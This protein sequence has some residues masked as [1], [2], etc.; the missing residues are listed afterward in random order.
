VAAYLGRLAAAYRQY[1][2][3]AGNG[4]V[5]A[6]LRLGGGDLRGLDPLPPARSLPVLNTRELAGL[7]HLP[8]AGADVPLLERTAARQRLPLPCT[9]GRGCRIG[10]SA[11]QGHEVPVSLPDELLRRHLLLVA[12]TR[13]GKSSLLLRLARYL[14]E[15]EPSGGRRPAL[16]LVD[17]HRDL[18]ETALGCVPPG[19]HGDVVYL[20]VAE[21]ERPFGLNLLDVGFG[22]ERD[23]AVSNVLD[24]FRHEWGRN[25]GPRMEDAFRY[26]LMTLF[27]ANEELCDHGERACN[28]QFTILDVPAVLAETGFRRWLLEMVADPVIEE[29]WARFDYLD[30]RLQMEIQNPVQT[31]VHKFAGSRAARAIVGQPRSTIDPAAWL[32]D[33]A[34]VLVNTAKGVVGEDTAALIGGTLLN[35]VALVV[36]EQ[37]GLRAS[38]RRPVTLVVDEF[39]S[40][41]GADY[42]SILAELPKYGANL[43]LATQSLARLDALDREHQRALRATVFSNLDG[44][45][46][47]HTSA[48]DARYLVHELGEGVD[49]EDLVGLGEHRCYARLSAGGERLPTFSVRLDPPPRPDPGLR[50]RLAAAS[51]ALY[52]RDR[53]E[54]EQGLREGLELVASFRRRPAA[55]ADGEHAADD[56]SARRQRKRRQRRDGGRTATGADG[57]GQ[58]PLFETAP[59]PAPPDGPTGGEEG[60][61]PSGSGEV[62]L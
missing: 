62:T 43:L 16:V 40:A 44:L 39:H 17:P 25:W 57:A 50:D 48:E 19:R 10:V 55:P 28:R 20:D 7:W 53:L 45:F 14:M 34:L 29:W 58:A 36:G 42:E 1:S 6:P 23:K 59:D 24:I 27:E 54:V 32:R 13:R 38:E 4:L 12:K 60:A 51:A 11:H 35:L 37:A 18:A 2:L 52:G 56:A 41:P 46:A 15:A 47:F 26:A 9:V 49:E 61:G 8:Q 30:R 31:K 21:Q 22:W 33:G 5:P 3:A